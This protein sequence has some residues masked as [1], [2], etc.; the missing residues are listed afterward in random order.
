MALD[1]EVFIVAPNV[2]MSILAVSKLT[3]PYTLTQTAQNTVKS[4]CNRGGPYVFYG[5]IQKRDWPVV[6]TDRFHQEVE[7]MEEI[8]VL[9]VGF[10][11][12]R[13][14]RLCASTRG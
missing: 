6:A 7:R 5:A 14:D 1:A 10:K 11:R 3:R 8:P 2:R 9:P 4:S 12:K 13:Q